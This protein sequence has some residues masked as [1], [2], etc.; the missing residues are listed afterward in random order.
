MVVGESRVG[1]VDSELRTRI[2]L[3]AAQFVCTVQFRLANIAA[4]IEEEYI[5]FITIALWH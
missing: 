5:Y 4:E 3:E 2:R 1:S